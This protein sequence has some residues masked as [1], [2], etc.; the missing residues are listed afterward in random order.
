[1]IRTREKISSADIIRTR[2]CS[3]SPTVARQLVVLLGM[4]TSTTQEEDFLVA[5]WSLYYTGG[6]LSCS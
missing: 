3:F 4:T 1:M 6:G 2:C 5:K